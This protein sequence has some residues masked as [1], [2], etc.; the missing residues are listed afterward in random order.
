MSNAMVPQK[1]FGKQSSP[2]MKPGSTHELFHLSLRI[3]FHVCAYVKAGIAKGVRR[4]V[5]VTR[6]LA[7]AAVERA[8]AFEL[9]LD[10]ADGIEDLSLDTMVRNAVMWIF[11]NCY[12]SSL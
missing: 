3:S 7:H 2:G 1:R 6:G 5:G 8:K 4:I 10:A 12:S 9:Q 11:S